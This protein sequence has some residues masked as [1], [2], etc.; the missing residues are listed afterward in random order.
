MIE[1]TYIF[2]IFTQINN[3][4]NIDNFKKRYREEFIILSLYIQ[5]ILIF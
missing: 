4:K 5:E 2:L 3:E 1:K